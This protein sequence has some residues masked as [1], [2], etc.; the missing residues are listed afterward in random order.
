MNQLYSKLKANL[1]FDEEKHNNIKSANRIVNNSLIRNNS[2]MNIKTI[3]KSINPQRNRSVAENNY[4]V[5]SS[6]HEGKITIRDLLKDEEFKKK[7]YGNSSFVR[8]SS[9]YI[10]DEERRKEL[11]KKN[12]EKWILKKDFTRFNKVKERFIHNYVNITK[13]NGPFKE[14]RD[15]KKEKWIGK[16]DFL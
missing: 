6:I 9:P 7:Y 13:Y 1:F 12:K 14:F 2:F 4:S 11:E 16:K 10:S 15:V 8:I 5:N 3:K